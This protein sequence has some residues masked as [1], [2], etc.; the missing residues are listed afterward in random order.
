MFSGGSI[1]LRKED[2]QSRA[3]LFKQKRTSW[4]GAPESAI[5][6]ECY[7]QQ[8]EDGTTMLLDTFV[9][10]EFL[11]APVLIV[12]GAASKKINA[13]NSKSM[14]KNIN[15]VYKC[16]VLYSSEFWGMAIVNIFSAEQVTMRVGYLV[17]FSPESSYS[18]FFDDFKVINIINPLTYALLF[19]LWTD[20]DYNDMFVF[21]VGNER[22]LLRLNEWPPTSFEQIDA[23]VIWEKINETKL[24]GYEKILNNPKEAES[25]AIEKEK[26]YRGSWLDE[27]PEPEWDLDYIVERYRP[28]N[29]MKERESWKAE[30]ESIYSELAKKPI[31]R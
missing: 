18:T 16:V 23:L 22:S 8:D 6:Y 26:Q 15:T 10:T 20:I 5:F 2:E 4:K 11:K 1:D 13:D 14:L 12:N 29:I 27:L 24:Q 31:L 25:Q 3:L 7:L 19:L 21:F 28:E 30:Y 9:R 17:G